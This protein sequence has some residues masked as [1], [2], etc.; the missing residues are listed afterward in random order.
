MEPSVPEFSI[1]IPAEDPNA[2]PPA[3]VP[4]SRTLARLREKAEAA[5][6]AAAA[7][8]VLAKQVQPGL[9]AP[10]G[11]L[12]ALDAKALVLRRHQRAYRAH[13]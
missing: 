1:T 11:R 6:R 8:T 5:R 4:S 7:A 9:R 13:A 10:P 3:R 2:P 12:F